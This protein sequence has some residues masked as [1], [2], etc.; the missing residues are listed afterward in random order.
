MIIKRENLYAYFSDFIAPDAD[1]RGIICAI[2]KN[3]GIQFTIAEISGSHHILVNL[4]E[5]QDNGQEITA[6]KKRNFTVLIAHYDRV[7]GSPGAN[8]NS[9]AVFMLVEAAIQLVKNK[10]RRWI[11]IFTDKE[12]ITAGAGIKSQGSYSLALGLKNLVLPGANFY[13]FDA[14]GSGDTLILSTT[15]EYLLKEEKGRGAMKTLRGIERLRI[16]ALA[17]A[18]DLAIT[19]ILTAPTPFSDDAGFLSAGIPAQTIT[20]LPGEEAAALAS[21]L[22]LNPH[23]AES[24]VNGSRE[25]GFFPETWRR[26]NSPEDTERCLTPEQFNR[27]V[28]FACALCSQRSPGN[29]T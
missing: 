14:C 6:W 28:R 25:S 15:L 10:E 5:Y 24:L 13:I 19:K 1:R 11:L 22:R 21:A 20:V 3:Q 17:C 8:D 29:F 7:P 26:I 23:L 16:K 18:K 12:E 4:Q 9:A 2:L 27:I